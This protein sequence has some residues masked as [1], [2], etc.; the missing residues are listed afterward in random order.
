MNNEQLIKW[1]A[2]TITGNRPACAASV[3]VGDNGRHK[4]FSEYHLILSYEDENGES[5]RIEVTPEVWR[6]ALLSALA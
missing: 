2:E 3:I 1:L 6:N 4:S 5:G